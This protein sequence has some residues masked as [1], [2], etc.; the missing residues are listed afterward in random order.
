MATKARQKG[1]LPFKVGDSV[2]IPTEIIAAEKERVKGEIS[3]RTRTLPKQ[4][5]REW[6]EKD[7]WAKSNEAILIEEAHIE[8]LKTQ[9]KTYDRLGTS[10]NGV[11]KVEQAARSRITIEIEGVELSFPTKGLKK[12]NGRS[13]T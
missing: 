13:E 11:H 3:I 1:P 8:R 10:S 7:P 6:K 5:K 9:L 2:V 12:I 4:E